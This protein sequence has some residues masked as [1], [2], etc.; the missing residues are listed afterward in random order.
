MIGGPILDIH[1]IDLEEIWMHLCVYVA[2]LVG[3]PR[4]G[5]RQIIR[6]ADRWAAKKKDK[7][8]L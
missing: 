1:P 2:I 6:I 8:P 3:I 5:G 7:L 4:F